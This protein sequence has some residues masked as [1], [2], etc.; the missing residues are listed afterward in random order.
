M[1]SGWNNVM[2]CGAVVPGDR[3]CGR[4][5]RSDVLPLFIKRLCSAL[6]TALGRDHHHHPLRLHHHRLHPIVYHHFRSGTA[7]VAVHFVAVI[8]FAHLLPLVKR[9]PTRSPFPR[10]STQ[11]LSPF[12]SSV[13]F[14]RLSWRSIKSLQLLSPPPAPH[15]RFPSAKHPQVH[16][17]LL[18]RAVLL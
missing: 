11:Q 3:G 15:H 9:N 16:H 7:C 4:L 17:P 5:E 1:C 12:F 10:S 8:I 14:D 6:A 13:R 2:I 18:S